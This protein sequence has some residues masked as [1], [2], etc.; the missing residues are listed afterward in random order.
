MDL[1]IRAEKAGGVLVRTRIA[2]DVRQVF[3]V[4]RAFGTPTDDGV[5][6][7]KTKWEASIWAS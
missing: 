3:V 2:P 6:L 4:D 7:V 5:A 1:V